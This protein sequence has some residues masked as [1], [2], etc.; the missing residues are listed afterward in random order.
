VTKKGEKLY[1]HVFDWPADGKLTVSPLPVAQ[2]KEVAWKAHLL[3][4]AKP[5]KV[6]VIGDEPTISLPTQPVDAIDTVVVLE[7]KHR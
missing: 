2:S 1:L 7:S 4:D 3:T 6:E 5:L